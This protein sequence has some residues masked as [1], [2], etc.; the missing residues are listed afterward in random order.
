[1]PHSTWR[2]QAIAKDAQ[3]AATLASQANK[4]LE[5]AGRKERIS[6]VGMESLARV[7]DHL[8]LEATK[9]RAA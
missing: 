2:L 9:L 7:A 3:G 6:T 5:K 8:R 4:V 1:M